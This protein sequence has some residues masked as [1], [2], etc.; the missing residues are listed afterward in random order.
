[1]SEDPAQ[2]LKDTLYAAATTSTE[3]AQHNVVDPIRSYMTGEKSPESLKVDID[4]PD[5]ECEKIDQMDKAK[6]AEF[7]QE[8]HKSNAGTKRR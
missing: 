4:I 8:R 5:D 2:Q 1:M 7:L 3:W 6:I